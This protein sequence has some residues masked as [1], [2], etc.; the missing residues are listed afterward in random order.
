ML[1]DT[2]F[3]NDLMGIP[4]DEDGGGLSAFY[5]FSAMGFYPVIPGIPEY[6]LG[7]PLFSK[8]RIRLE[9]G[10]FFTIKAGSNSPEKKYI[11]SANLNGHLLAKPTLTHQDIIS[12]GTLVLE[13]GKKPVYSWGNMNE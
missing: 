3:R 11:R 13:M 9:N 4:G 5:V 6:Q 10:E 2:W 12:G 7:S 8:V 1:M